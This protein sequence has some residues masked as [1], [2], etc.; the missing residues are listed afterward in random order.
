MSKIEGPSGPQVGGIGPKEE[1][2]PSG[3]IAKDKFHPK[4]KNPM[5]DAMIKQADQ[6]MSADQA[7]GKLTPQSVMKIAKD[8]NLSADDTAKIKKAL[9]N[10]PAD[11]P[12]DSKTYKDVV[13]HVGDGTYNRMIIG[14]F[15]VCMSQLRDEQNQMKRRESERKQIYGQ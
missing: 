11:Q 12:L 7:K 10:T 15:N 4:Q 5:R 9:K 14:I 13:Q 8:M 1:S 2:E 3:A 6:F